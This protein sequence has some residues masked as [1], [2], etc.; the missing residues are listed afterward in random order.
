MAP[1]SYWSSSSLLHLPFLLCCFGSILMSLGPFLC[2]VLPRLS[3]LVNFHIP[4]FWIFHFFCGE[5][6]DTVGVSLWRSDFVV[7]ERMLLIFLG[8]SG[9]C[10]RS[11]SIAAKLFLSFAALPLR[12][13]IFLFF[14]FLFFC[15]LIVKFSC[16]FCWF[17]NFS[18]VVD[19]LSNFSLV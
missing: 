5:Y 13:L 8:F 7:T 19:Y 1:G 9:L 18:F 4:T 12:C 3:L 6:S 17:F 10:W 15:C 14:F 11:L 2:V 16:V